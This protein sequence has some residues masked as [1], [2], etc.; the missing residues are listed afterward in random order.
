[1]NGIQ[2]VQLKASDFA[3][4]LTFN[5]PGTGERTC[6]FMKSVGYRS[7]IV[8]RAQGPASPST[9]RGYNWRACL[10]ASIIHTPLWYGINAGFLPTGQAEIGLTDQWGYRGGDY[11][12]LEITV[13]WAC[14]HA[15]AQCIHGI[16]TYAAV[17]YITKPV[18]QSTQL[19]LFLPK[20]KAT[21]KL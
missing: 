1:M 14:Q 16:I 11:I 10:S 4:L 5:P 9:Q 3:H 12:H 13:V 2:G 15:Y 6:I 20:Q 7:G 8:G 17:W 19:G 21:Y 18:I